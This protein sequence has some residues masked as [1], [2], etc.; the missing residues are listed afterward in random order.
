MKK[1]N[2]IKILNEFLEE[3]KWKYDYDEDSS[4]YDFGINLG[5]IIGNIYFVI[6]VRDHYYKAISIFNSKCEKQNRQNIA[7]YLHRANFGMNNGNFELD[8]DDGEVRFK[9]YIDCRGRTLSKKTVE[10]SIVIPI[11]MFKRYGKN[12]LKLM[13]GEGN[14]KDLIR[15]VENPDEL[16]IADRFD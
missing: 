12:L 13:L 6:T 11:V 10:E 8:V 7:E 3:Q 9:T 4:T 16:R 2:V 5:N 14:P 15:E 1:E